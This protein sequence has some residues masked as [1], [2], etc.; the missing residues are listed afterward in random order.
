MGFQAPPLEDQLAAQLRGLSLLA[1]SQSEADEAARNLV[2]FVRLLAEIDR[3]ESERGDDRAGDRSRHRVREA[4]T[5]ADRVRQR[6]A[7]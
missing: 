7:R 6:R 2:G 1:M 5:R 3:N 4:Q